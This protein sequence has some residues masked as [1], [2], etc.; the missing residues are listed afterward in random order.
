MLCHNVK[1]S[2][3]ASGQES[4]TRLPYPGARSADHRATASPTSNICTYYNARRNNSLLENFLN[5][6]IEFVKT[7][8]NLYTKNSF[9]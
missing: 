7:P 2:V 4:T 6:Y 8:E 1:S 3:R 5:I 9:T